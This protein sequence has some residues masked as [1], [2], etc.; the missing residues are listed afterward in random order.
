MKLNIQTLKMGLGKKLQNINGLVN[1]DKD[2]EKRT[3]AVDRMIYLY[4]HLLIFT[5]IYIYLYL[6]FGSSKKLNRVGQN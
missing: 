4:L 1:I 5:Y 2:I 3:F 6:H